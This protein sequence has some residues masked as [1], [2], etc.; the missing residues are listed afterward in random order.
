MSLAYEES[1]ETKHWLS[2]LKDTGY[3][4]EPAAR[5]QFKHKEIVSRGSQIMRI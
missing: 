4:D 1:L 2:L 3:I 5:Y